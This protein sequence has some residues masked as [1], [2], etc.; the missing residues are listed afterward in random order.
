MVN[1]KT[2]VTSSME[3]PFGEYTLFCLNVEGRWSVAA[4]RCVFL[5]GGLCGSR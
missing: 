5:L 2:Q 1:V 4:A 3:H